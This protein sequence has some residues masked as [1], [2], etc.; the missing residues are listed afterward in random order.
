[1]T[2]R[3]YH[4]RVKILHIISGDLWAGAESQAFTLLSA[5]AAIPDINVTAALMN[6][7]DLAHRLRLQSIP[8]TVIPEDTLT[9]PQIFCQL[10]RIMMDLRPDVVHTHRVKENVLG[11]LANLTAGR[12]VCIRTVHG[13]EERKMTGLQHLAS[14][15]QALL[16]TF[17]GR[18]LQDHIIAVSAD[19][20]S[21]LR[22]TFSIK[23][24][25]TV[26]N[27]I[28]ISATR[29][30]SRIANLRR[31]GDAAIHTGIIGRLVPVKRIDMF[32][33]TAAILAQESSHLWRFH[34][35][36]DGPLKESLR[37]KA[38]R[39]GVEDITVFH[40]HRSDVAAL[41]ASLDVM[42]ICSDHEGLPMSLLEA[43]AVG[44]P[45]VAHAV[46]G[47]PAA[48]GNPAGC[49]LVTT[50]QPEA[51]ANAVREMLQQDRHK[52]STELRHRVECHYSSTQNA[53][54]VLSIYTAEIERQHTKRGE[55]A[56]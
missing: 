25:S 15:A 12:A 2:P 18:F 17:C 46:G 47:I 14:R 7:G 34:I 4:Y 9:S 10:R 16:N 1:M 42:L 33:Q 3:R 31:D 54:A 43:M 51:Y 39:L 22:A 6:E 44:T 52:I 29:N 8:V 38:S 50:H 56:D 30:A 11:S 49:S 55:L 23:R 40:G 24:V 28:D 53:A 19:L 21:Q 37:D 20:A 13:A 45:V 5:L 41:I 35:I 26:E 48:L 36:G 27:G 32:L